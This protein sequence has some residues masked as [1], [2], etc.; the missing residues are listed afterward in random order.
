MEA[1]SQIPTDVASLLK[2]EHIGY[3]SLLDVLQ[4]E[5]Q[6]LIERDFDT[7]AQ[8]LED[9]H[10]LVTQL[11]QLAEHRLKVLEALKFEQSELGMQAL[12]ERQPEYGRLELEQT[13]QDI[14][15]QVKQCNIQNEVNSKIAHRA[16]TTSRQILNILKGAPNSQPLYDK[17]GSAGGTGSGFSITRA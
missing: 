7:F 4:R 15:A 8:V 11:D 16:Q 5:K 17:T 10:R 3:S 1:K 14:K 9:K 13:W 12:L 2:A 6:L